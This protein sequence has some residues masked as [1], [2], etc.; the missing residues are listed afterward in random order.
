MRCI[1]GDDKKD[2]GK[3]AKAYVAIPGILWELCL[4]HA[5]VCGVF[6]SKFSSKKGN[7]RRKT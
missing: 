2:C 1:F 5:K 6:R 4:K 3:P 7:R